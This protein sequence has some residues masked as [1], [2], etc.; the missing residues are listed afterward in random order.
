MACSNCYN[1][2]AEIVSDK[3]V[4][5]TG[6][7]VP[8]LG[9]QSGDSL[10]YVEQALIEFLTAA[11][12][13]TG[14][15]INIPPSHLCELVTKYIPDCGEI[16]A[17]VLFDALI[18]AACD[19]QNQIDA[20][21][22][23]LDVLNADYNVDC[24][25]GVTPSSDTHAVLQAVISK[26]CIVDSDLT[27][28]EV[29][30]NTNFVKLA[31]LNTLIQAYLD[32]ITPAITQQYQKMVP[33][34]VVE[35]YGP[36]TNFDGTGKGVAGLGWD[37]VYLCNGLNG[38]PDKRG[39]LPV[40]AISGVPGGPLDPAVV[41]GGFNPNYTLNYTTGTNSFSITN[42]NQLPPHTHAAT[43]VVTDP[44]HTHTGTAAGPYAGPDLSGGFDGG[45]NIWKNRPITVNNNVTGI[46]V[47]TTNATVG[48]NS[49]IGHIPPVLACYYIMYIP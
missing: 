11:I 33:Y 34:T 18:Q 21:T 5:Y 45:G 25:S 6:I 48:T 23:E 38:T 16:T 3:C 30:V 10:S 41:P 28:F 17:V 12:D 24:L 35:Y 37:K 20:I 19:L 15:K 40:G 43:S 27:A 7:D 39:R 31:D 8:V 49:P 32:S 46:T 4:K 47:T 26:L 13:G 42:A 2:C 9:I 14:I 29:D 36:L 44:G 22:T 1:G